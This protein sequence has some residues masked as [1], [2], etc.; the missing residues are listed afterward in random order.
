MSLPQLTRVTLGFAVGVGFFAPGCGNDTTDPIDDVGNGDGDGDGTGDGDG[1][2]DTESDSGAGDGDGDG[3]GDDPTPLDQHPARGITI[4]QVEAN[5]GTAVFIG[6]DGEWV[7]PEQRLGPLVKNRNTLIRIHYE[8]DAS[9]VPRQIE[10][11]M[12][13]GFTDGTSRTLKQVRDVSAPSSPNALSE[14]FFFGLV[15]EAGEVVPGMTFKVEMHEVDPTA[16]GDQPEGVWQTPPEPE[17]LGIE[18]A[19]LELK[20]VF[21]PYHHLYDEIDRVADT[22]D[23]NMKVITDFLYEHNPVEKLI[24]EVHAPELWDLPMESL[25][26]VL[27]PM[28]ALRDNE[29]APPNVYYHALFPVPQ[30]GVAGVAG[31]ASVP[32]DGFGEGN[33]RVAVSALGNNVSG[34]A[35]VVVHEVGHNEGLQHVFCPFAQAASPDPT[36]PYQNGLLGTWGFGIISLELKSPD[37]RY[38]YMSYCNPSWVSSWSWGK[39]FTRARTLTAWDYEGPE[40]GGFDFAQGPTGYAE[41]D[42]LTGSINPDGTEFWWTSHGTL[43]TGADPYG[44]DYGHYLELRGNGE[45]LDTLPAVVRYTNEF[46]TAWVI[47]ELPAEFAALDGVDEIIRHDDVDLTYVVPRARVQLSSRGPAG[48]HARGAELTGTQ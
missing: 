13:L 27:G 45:L 37:N 8:I 5:Q 12:I 35:G 6:E 33:S 16:G 43:P 34:T 29:L 42:L 40:A 22:S 7:V 41:G 36:Y 31:V 39:T 17:E 21:V 14:I 23:A 38:D 2:T 48:T 15:A 18:S 44:Q 32:G 25:G 10:A 1:E 28:A 46:S 30:G 4:T 11:R 20:I 3:E 9:F 19:P 47:A 24:W 26:A